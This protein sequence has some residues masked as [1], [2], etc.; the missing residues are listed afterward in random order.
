MSDSHQTST[1]G[2]PLKGPGAPLNDD[3]VTAQHIQDRTA[4]IEE[5]LS[6]ISQGDLSFRIEEA[7]AEIGGDGRQVLMNLDEMARRLRYI[8]GRLQRAADSIDA[9]VGEVLRGTQTLSSGVID[10]A[11]SVEDTSTSISEINASVHSVGTSLETLSNLSQSTSISISEMATSIDNVSQN[12]DELAQY[13]EDTASAIEEMAV[14]VRKVAESTEALAESAEKT[15]RAMEAIDT[16]TQ[17]IGESVNETTDLAEDVAQSA[18][19]GSRLVGET[20]ESMSKIKEAID[21]ATETITRLGHRSDEIGDITHVINEIADR[22][23]LLA[24]N[25]AILAAQAGAQGRGF[26]IVADEIK[27]LSERTSASTRE[28]DDLIKSVRADVTETIDRVAV[29]G[30]RAAD[31]VDL[32]SRAASLLAEIREKT[33]ASSEAIRAIADASAIQASESHTVLEAA[34]LVRQ[35]ARGIERATGEQALTSRH[36]GERASHMSELTGQVRTATGE[37]A[38]VSKYIA[39]AMEELTMAIEQI[40]GASD[41]QASGTDK[42]LA[43]IEAIKEVVARN[44]ASISG[45]NSAVDLLVREAEL[46]NRE[47]EA[48]KLP[49]PERGGSLRFGLRA[50]QIALDPAAVSSSSRIEVISNILEGLVQFGERAEIRPCIAERWEISPDGKVYTFYLRETARFHNGRRVRAD[51]VKYSFERQMRQNEDAAAW[52]F[53]PLV[54]ADQFMSGES[55]SVSGI[56]VLG[57]HVVKL[58]MKQQVAFFLSTLCTDYAYIIPR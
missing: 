16:S 24:L 23:N 47:V 10:E 41:E 34:D 43:A 45:I 21:A 17:R 9:V 48:F 12:V 32:A 53:R 40:R 35:Q 33:I 20:A 52:V 18:G 5:A 27:E 28:I 25:A 50:S 58:E 6:R 36:I 29:G 15:A 2:A 3:G 14:S 39:E 46:L 1:P 54:G 22:T 13:V 56:E 42:V 7:G 38:R 30:A 49:L 44:Q 19:A 57:E 55:E 31:G 4:Q 51:D 37:Q 26:R 11:R 8:V